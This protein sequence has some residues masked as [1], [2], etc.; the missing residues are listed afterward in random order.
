MPELPDNSLYA[1]LALIVAAVAVL[2]LS[3]LAHMAG[4][5]DRPDDDLKD[6]A[7]DT[8]IVGGIAIFVAFH[9]GLAVAGDFDVWLF[10]LTAF[11][12]VVGLIDD[13]LGLSPLPR[14]G[15]GVV[16]GIL[17]VYSVGADADLGAAVLVV[18]LL[19]VALNAVNLLD[20][21]DAVAGSAALVSGIGLIFL[22][23]IRSVDPVPALLLAGAAGGFLVVNWPPARTFLGDGGAYVV[24]SALTYLVVTSS[25]HPIDV[26]G[27]WLPEVLVA[28]LLF[29]V[30]IVDL[31]VTLLRRTVARQPLFGGDRSHVY[32]QL[33]DRGWTPARVATA[34]AA[35]QLAIVTLVVLSVLILT[36]WAAFAVSLF[37]IHAVIT[38][39]CAMGFAYQ[40]QKRTSVKA[41]FQDPDSAKTPI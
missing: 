3:P 20:G 19:V 26:S 28:A 4:L 40:P 16:A 34:V 12:L 30:F 2:A 23:L 33:A 22:A 36:P 1:V 25:D 15:A 7:R 24:A 5:V 9:L 11:L 39:L 14:L 8:P 35:T 17:L 31:A 13:V 41:I 37:V 21:A 6:H 32:D 18:A 27:E 29:G 10:G 38:M